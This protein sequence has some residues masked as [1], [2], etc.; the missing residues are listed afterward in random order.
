M[1]EAD[2]A[3]FVQR[4]DPDRFL[5]AIFAPPARRGSLFALLALNHELARAR[6]ATRSPLPALVRLQWWRDV[7]EEAAAGRPPRAH[8]VAAS[9]QRAIAAGALSPADLLALIDPREVEVEEAMPT[10]A[11]FDA[12]LADSAGGL[13]VAAGR[14]LGVPE[15]RLPAVRAA[16]ALYGLAGM[17]RSVPAWAAQ[18]RCGLPAE[19][20]ATARLS[21]EAVVAAPHAP[22]VIAI[23]RTMAAE[24][25]HRMPVVAGAL[26]GLPRAALPAVLPLVLAR[27]DLRRLATGRAVPATRGL[28]DRLAVIVAGLRGRA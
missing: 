11:A 21:V 26:H 20:L 23:T 27:R 10:R 12:Y 1:N 6:D 5:A 7:V 14:L 2:L 25:L 9:L 8:A 19:L 17:L 16:G 18:G 28:L 4:H 24:G 22:A 15:A 3:A 13:A